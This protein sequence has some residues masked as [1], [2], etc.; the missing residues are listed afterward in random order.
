MNNIDIIRKY[1]FIG[2]E[3]GRITPYDRAT[4]LYWAR[5]KGSGFDI[6]TPQDQAYRAGFDKAHGKI[7]DSIAHLRNARGHASRPEFWR[8]V[9]NL[10]HQARL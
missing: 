10:V 1:F 2:L 5:E 6:F 7:H 8:H 4:S 3:N 9:S